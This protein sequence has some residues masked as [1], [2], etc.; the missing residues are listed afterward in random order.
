M[1]G[2]KVKALWR[3]A[4]SLGYKKM[5]DP[6]TGLRVNGIRR[7]RRWYMREYGKTPEVIRG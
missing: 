6:R 4:A 2:T 3:L 7:Y 1:R 5:V